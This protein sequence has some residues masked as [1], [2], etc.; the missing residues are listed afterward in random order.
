MPGRHDG[1]QQRRGH[2]GRECSDEDVG[3]QK[4]HAAAQHAGNG[5]GGRGRGHQNDEPHGLCDK[6]VPPDENEVGEQAPRRLQTEQ[7]D[8]QPVNSHRSERHAAEREQ[9][10][11]REQKRRQ[12]GK[13]G[14]HGMPQRSRDDGH[15]QSPLLEKNKNTFH[16]LFPELFSVRRMR[17][18]F[19]CSSNHSRKDLTPQPKGEKF[20]GASWPSLHCRA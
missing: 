12:E 2:N 10:H 11:G 1:H 15:H 18:V 17:N 4:P 13:T 19:R 16:D 9:Q 6:G 7:H 3:G 5:G 8:M 20:L 14:E